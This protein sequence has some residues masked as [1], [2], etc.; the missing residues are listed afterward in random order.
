M[1]FC[2]IY[3]MASEK[4]GHAKL[5]LPCC[6]NRFEMTEILLTIHPSM[7]F[8]DLA[9]KQTNLILKDFDKVNHSKL[10]RK[11]HQYEIRGNALSWI[12]AF[13]GNRSQT[14][15]IE[16]EESGSVP[17][18]LGYPRAQSLGLFCFLY[19]CSLTTFRTSCH[20]RYAYLL[21]TQ[22]CT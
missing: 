20:R 15:V 18:T 1:T 5:S 12:H 14:V 13:L 22:P 4:K 2:T 6:S 21:I 10:L 9:G 11:L 17:V 7:L 19:T 8:E 3:N 16:G